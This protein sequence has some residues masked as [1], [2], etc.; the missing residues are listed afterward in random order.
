MLPIDSRWHSP[1]CRADVRR[2]RRTGSSI[3]TIPAR[4]RFRE[5]CA[6]RA[7]STTQLTAN[8][9]IPK[10]GAEGVVLSQ[11]GSSGGYSL[12]IKNNK[13]HYAH[14]YVGDK[15]FMIVFEGG[16]AR[17]ERLLRFEFE[18]TGKPDLAK[19]LG[20]AGMGA[21]LHRRQAERRAGA[22]H[23]DSARHRNTEGLVCGRDPGSAVS[24]NTTRPSTSRARFA[25]SSST[26]PAI[27]SW[28]MKR[29][30]APSW[31]INKAVSR[32]GTVAARNGRT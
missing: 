18:P 20:A 4:R 3:A 26:F 24:R 30:C 23:D 22:V 28:T 31:H 7:Q 17:G 21:A 32:R 19:G 13:L 8:I 15:E 29:G 9:E 10:G 25:M 12:F 1:T 16:R 11:G 2:S 27:S 5:G 14:N 6:E